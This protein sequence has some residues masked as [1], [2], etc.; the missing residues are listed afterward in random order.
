MFSV[1]LL[2][3][4]MT[5][6][7]LIQSIDRTTFLIIPHNKCFYQALCPPPVRYFGKFKMCLLKKV[8][9]N[10]GKGKGNWAEQFL[11]LAYLYNSNRFKMASKNKT[12]RL[13]NQFLLWL[14]MGGLLGI[15]C[16]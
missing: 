5:A 8:I 4:W 9:K 2:Q 13:W 15:S 7:L 1:M 16:F 14:K 12:F 11:Y 3:F 10:T 6:M